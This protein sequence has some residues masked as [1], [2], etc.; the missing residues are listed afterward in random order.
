MQDSHTAQLRRDAQLKL[1][2]LT[3]RER[4]YALA[5]VTGA[6]D[7]ELAAQFFVSE[8]TVKSALA[9]I[10]MKLGLRTK[11]DVAVLV[12]RAGN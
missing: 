1:A 5:T 8:T 10:R 12:A 2:T 11:T 6:S 3:E 4:E 7:A 9:T